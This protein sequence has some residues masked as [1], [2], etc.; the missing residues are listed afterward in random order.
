MGEVIPKPN[1]PSSLRN[2]KETLSLFVTFKDDVVEVLPQPL[3]S[4]LERGTFVP[5]PAFSQVCANKGSWYRTTVKATVIKDFL[6]IIEGLDVMIQLVYIP[7][8]CKKVWPKAINF[9]RKQE[10]IGENFKIKYI[11]SARKVKLTK[12]A[13]GQW[14]HTPER[15]QNYSY[16]YAF[17]NKIKIFLSHVIFIYI[18]MIKYY[19]FFCKKA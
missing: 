6:F 8:L 11:L 5:I 16:T 13:P 1:R 17:T 18:I 2:N 3:I 14:G 4:N 19:I 7:K 9:Q 12:S 15:P 10:R